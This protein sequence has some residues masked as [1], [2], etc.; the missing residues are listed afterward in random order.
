MH[1]INSIKKKIIKSFGTVFTN[2]EDVTESLID[3][4]NRMLESDR[5]IIIDGLKKLV[6]DY[7]IPKTCKILMIGDSV[8]KKVASEIIIR[9]SDW[10]KLCENSLIY[11]VIYQKYYKSFPLEDQISH[12]EFN[13]NDFIKKIKALKLNHLNNFRLDP[14]FNLSGWMNW[15]GVLFTNDYY[16]T[17]NLKLN[18]ILSDIDNLVKNFPF[19]KF[20]IQ[21]IEENNKKY[22]IIYSY[23]I[24]DTKI[25]K[26]KTKDLIVD[27]NKKTKLKNFSNEFILKKIS[28]E[29][30]KLLPK[31]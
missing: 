21:I 22:K 19:L 3:G 20:K 9:T 29:I 26:F 1:D 31:F 28:I 18:N 30:E 11:N 23:E 12:I 17:P 6:L 25:K 15:N 10:N 2:P 14:L 7:K 8:S 13:Q 4:L 24:E 16:L 27:P 5:K